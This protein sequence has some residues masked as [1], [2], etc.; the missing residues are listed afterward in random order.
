[1]IIESVWWGRT[2]YMDALVQMNQM[3]ADVIAGKCPSTIIY[4]EHN[5]VI[6]CGRNTP[7]NQIFSKSIPTAEVN[8]GGLATWHG[9][10]QLAAYPVIN[11][12]KVTQNNID[13]HGFLRNIELGI[14]AF[15]SEQ[16]SIRA[17]QRPQF[18]GVW[19]DTDAPVQRKIAS[20]GISVRRFVTAHGLALN[21]NPSMEAFENIIPCGLTGIQMTSVAQEIGT[22]TAATTSLDLEKLYPTLH[23]SLLRTIIHNDN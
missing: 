3:Q 17:K 9:P 12:R 15:L 1:M 22:T 14:I 16:F 23:Q 5:P 7:P 10:G 8:R 6:T 2:Q 13:L 19:I 11:L 20:I 4:T 21:I 18:T